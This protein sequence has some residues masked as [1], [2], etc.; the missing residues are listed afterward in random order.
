MGRERLSSGLCLAALAG[1]RL[2]GALPAVWGHAGGVA[3][4]VPKL[5]IFTGC[6]EVSGLCT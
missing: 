1:T 5:G 2:G 6:G 3:V 4:F